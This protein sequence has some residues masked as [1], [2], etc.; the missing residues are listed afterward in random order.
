MNF[1]FGY[2]SAAAVA[3]AAVSGPAWADLTAQ[4]VW[5]D[6][7]D[8]MSGVGYE[9]SATE[10]QS[11]D[12]LTVSDLSLSMAIPDSDGTM[13]FTADKIE[14]KENGDGT[15]T[16]MMPATMPMQIAG[17]EEGS[18]FDVTVNV[19]QSGHAMTA[20]GSPDD[21]TYAYSA[22]AMVMRLASIN[23]D[24][25]DM[26][27]AVQIE[28][29]INNIASE[30]AMKIGD[31]RSYAQ[32]MTSSGVT[33]N[34]TFDDPESDDGGSMVGSMSNVAFQG[35]G[36]I[37]K[38]MD[39]T[40]MQ[41]MV[42]AGFAFDGTFSHGGG[43]T[44]V[45][46]TDAGATF[47]YASTSQGGAIQ[48]AMD[49]SRLIYDLSQAQTTLNVV[50]GD[51]PF[52]V[53]LEMAEA[54]FRMLMPVGKSDTAQDFELVVKLG[55]FTMSDMIWG[56]IDPGGALP[57]DPASVIVDL[58]GKA[59]ILIDLLGPDVAEEVMGAS[60]PPGELEALTLRNLL[61]SA[62][63]AELSGTGDFTFKNGGP[64]PFG[65]FPQPVGGVDLKLV[66]A[67]GLIDKL[68]QMGIVTDQDAMG[69]RMMM[70]MLAVPGEGEDT[71]T[72]KIEMNEEGHIMANG[73]RIQ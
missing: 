1:K 54:G 63:G 33:Y 30:T 31:L 46:G 2:C 28:V 45:S 4:D 11:G 52:P 23:V 29:A 34:F 71:L 69:A 39:T 67:N 24:G 72:S 14:F 18:A 8:Y 42:K 48:V 36:D 47:Q 55:D 50:G 37:P 13:S 70:G 21:L 35:G 22:D 16:I 68:I 19:E 53:S 25:E 57:R 10:D 43:K 60:A 3:F 26:S 44:D 73:Q 5:S 12:T 51:I 61:V 66:G 7:R 15:V 32:N 56:M 38:D 59:K 58:A 20:S 40:D 27:S 62:A 17:T 41:A 64:S 6:W 49:A 65:P 9:V